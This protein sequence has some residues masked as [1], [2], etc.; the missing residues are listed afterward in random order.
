[1]NAAIIPNKFT[2]F[3]FSLNA[4]NEYTKTIGVYIAVNGDAIDTN[5]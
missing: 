2:R 4:T 3:I 1:M 5:A